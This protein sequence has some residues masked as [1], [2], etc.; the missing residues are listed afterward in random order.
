MDG[1]GYQGPGVPYSN[2][3]RAYQYGF[4]SVLVAQL[5]LFPINM[6]IHF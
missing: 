6:I 3:W 5:L 2:V 1:L 4:A